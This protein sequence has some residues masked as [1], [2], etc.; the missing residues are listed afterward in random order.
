MSK[1]GIRGINGHSVM[2]STDTVTPSDP[3]TQPKREE[4]RTNEVPSM[5][6]REGDATHV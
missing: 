1:H 6:K 3:V 2:V 4:S 5:W